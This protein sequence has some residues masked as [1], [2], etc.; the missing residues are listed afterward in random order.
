MNLWGNDLL[1]FFEFIIK[2]KFL[3]KLNLSKNNLQNMANQILEKLSNFN[4]ESNCSLKFLSLEE[5]K[6]QDINLVLTTFLINNKNLE[7]LN[8]KNNLINDDIGNNYFFHG[9]FKNTKSNLKELDLSNNKLDLK[10]LEKLINYSKENKIEKKDFLL[11]VTSKE[12]REAYLKEN[13]RSI[14]WE[15]LGLNCIT[16][17]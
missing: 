17:F 14:Y 5:N 8:L 15:L 13:D 16:C 12:L 9:L 6:I 11:N 7:V 2:K 4:N 1:T 10:F 3:E